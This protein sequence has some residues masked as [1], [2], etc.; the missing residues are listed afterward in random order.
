MPMAGAIHG[1]NVYAVHA[2]MNI[3]T[4]K[5]IAAKQAAYSLA[6]GPRAATFALDPTDLAQ[7]IKP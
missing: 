6:S 7:N 5:S 1:T 2:K 4:G 3:P